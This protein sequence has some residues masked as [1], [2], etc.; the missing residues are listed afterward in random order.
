MSEQ[1]EDDQDF[2][3]SLK[4][5]TAETPTLKPGL[6]LNLRRIRRLLWA[7][8]ARI[9]GHQ[10]RSTRRSDCADGKYKHAYNTPT[11]PMNCARLLKLC[12][13]ANVDVGLPLAKGCF[14]WYLFFL[15]RCFSTYVKWKKNQKYVRVSFPGYVR[16][17]ALIVAIIEVIMAPP[18]GISVLKVAPTRVHRHSYNSGNFR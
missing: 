10:C 8:G 2:K 16:K 7:R 17:Y 1:S 12:W 14:P 4:T 11:F 3:P 9:L 5:A 18:Y 15:L 13:P 6:Y